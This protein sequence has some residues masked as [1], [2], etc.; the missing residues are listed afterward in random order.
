[1]NGIEY[2]LRE[3]IHFQDHHSVMVDVSAGLALGALPGLEDFQA[4]VAPVLPVIDGLVCSPGQLRRIERRKQDEAGL[5]VRLDWTNVLRGP[6][7]VLPP[8]RPQRVPLLSARDAS[9]LGACGM[10][11]SFL[12]G[13]EEE[14]EAACMKDTVQLALEGKAVGL[15]LVVEVR[16][17]GS[18]VSLY[19]KAVELGAS[20]ALEGGADVIVIPNP[21][22]E[23]L[24]TVAAFVS[25]P[26][27]MKASSLASAAQELEDVLAL[28]GTGLWLD[29]AVFDQS[30]PA[31]QLKALRHQL[32]PSLE[33]A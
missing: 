6:D 2:R 15:P 5:L 20:Y 4:G 28:G 22:K 12:L 21:G 32:H 3:F 10:V 23:S 31:E 9:D 24:K 17:T 25:V 26:W 1:M 19:G 11:I 13:Y 8:S 33:N 16:P 18:R 27:L 7:F 30:K 29:H 14:V